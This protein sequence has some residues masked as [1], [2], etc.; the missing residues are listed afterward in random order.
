MN[1]FVYFQ[2]QFCS[3]FLSL[4]H[5]EFLSVSTRGTFCGRQSPHWKML[6][7][8]G[9]FCVNP[10]FHSGIGMEIC[11]P[12]PC[13]RSH[14]YQDIGHLAYDSVSVVCNYSMRWHCSF[15]ME[16]GSYVTSVGCALPSSTAHLVGVTWCPSTEDVRGPESSNKLKMCSP[17]LIFFLR[18]L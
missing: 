5:K 11:N 9:I 18:I 8:G 14:R 2:Q 1:I 6:S 7:T 10:R 3:A 17:D 4:L 15:I 13:I 16:L 12:S